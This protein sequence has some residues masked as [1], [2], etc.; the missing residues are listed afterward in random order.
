VPERYAGASAGRRHPLLV[1]ALLVG[2]AMT[3][4]CAAV[5]QQ[6]SLS[7]PAFDPSVARP[8]YARASGP[9]TAFDEAHFNYHT[10]GGRY[11]AFAE[12][13]TSDGYRLSSNRERFS[14][15]MLRTADLVVIANALGAADPGDAAASSPA[16]TERE[17]ASLAEWVRQGGAL[18]LISDHQPTGAAAQVLATPLGVRMSNATVVDTTAA[19]HLQGYVETNLEFTRANGLVKDHAITRGR[20]STERIDRVV[21]FGGQS[22]KGPHD[23]V[24][25]LALGPAAVEV[26]PPSR[27]RA[28]PVGDCM[29]LAFPLGRGRVVVTGEAGMLS[30]QLVTDDGADG[31]TT[32]PWG[33]NWPG[34]DNRQ[35][36]LNIARWLTGALR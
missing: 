15:A 18:L 35:L 34:I 14:A 13:L 12:L 26:R 19:N 32:H 5:A 25:L 2:V 20:D 33:M 31:K 27:E 7:D 36:A 9:R 11:K 24:C 3:F 28:T 30:A 23:A 21:A 1:A 29:A 4:P 22:L 10:A 16:F 17:A 8:A 6:E